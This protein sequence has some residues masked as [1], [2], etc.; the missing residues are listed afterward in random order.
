MR[1]NDRTAIGKEPVLATMLLCFLIVTL[2]G[3]DT[4]SITFVAPILARDWGMAPAAMVPVFLATS[5]GA[6]IGYMACGPLALRFGTRSLALGS[7]LLFG[8]GSLATVLAG[9]IVSL[10]AL[11][12]ITALGLGG[13]L[14]VAI[15]RAADLMPGRRSATAAMIIA[16]GISA[17]G[18]LAGIAGGP[19]MAHAGWTSIFI[20]GGVL[21][22][23]LLPWIAIAIRDDGA[24]LRHASGGNAVS[25]L[26]GKGLGGATAMLWLFA[27]LVFLIAYA[28]TSWLPTLALQIG[29]APEKAPAV[30]AAFAMGGLIGDV[31]LILLSA[32][33]HTAT[34]LLVSATLG[35]VGVLLFGLV[36]VSEAA[37]MPLVILI[38]MGFIPCCVAQSALAVALYPAALRTTGI[39]WAAAMGRLGSIAGPGVGG[40]VLASGWPPQQIVLTAALPAVAAILL[41]PAFVKSARATT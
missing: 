33:I 13:A 3:F 20:V 34:T 15:S 17:G 11:R 29:L 14:P 6:V 9:D 7:V 31:L 27:F 38:G 22:L 32:R 5:V 36:G 35:L 12:F 2:D 30:A 26:F 39:G 25:A 24:R 4:I 21:P 1:D 41:L 16:T 18:V 28:L 19:L 23:L 10:T 40:L 37:I 8:L